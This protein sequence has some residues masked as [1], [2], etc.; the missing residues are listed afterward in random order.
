[1]MFL[2]KRKGVAWGLLG[3]VVIIFMMQ[4]SSLRRLVGVVVMAYYMV[5][6]IWIAIIVSIMY[7]LPR[8]H[9]P[10]KM[11]WKED[12]TLW[13]IIGATVLLGVKLLAG[14]LWGGFGK[15]PYDLSWYGIF[16]NSLYVVPALVGRELIRAYVIGSFARQKQ[17]QKMFW[18][19]TI[20]MALVQINTGAWVTVQG[21]ET[22]TV[23]LSKSVLPVICE[24]ILLS[25]LV[26]YGGAM[27]AILFGGIG[28]GF[29][30]LSPI[31]PTLEWFSQGVIGIAIPMIE[32]S[33]IQY[34]YGRLAKEV[35]PKERSQQG[36]AGWLIL[37]TFSVVLIWFVVGVFPVYPSIVLTG[38][39]EPKI[40]PGDVVLVEKLQTQEDLE[41]LQEGD[42]I[43]FSR[44]DIMITHRIVEVVADEYGNET[45][46]TK[47]DNNSGVDARLV[48]PQE[49][50]GTVNTVIPKIG[51]PSLWL[52][53]IPGH[54]QEEV[55][56]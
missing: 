35:K 29:W 25:Y 9:P 22:F 2:E 11:R 32:V 4:A 5:P 10:Q 8:V 43:Y 30:W 18:L 20:L 52:R 37:F 24:S 27:P 23:F 3:L 14:M 13:A 31:L 17:E 40:K 19:V 41:A 48:L 39:M 12:V 34:L 49:I 42:V 56:F 26:K 53:S 36:L 6:A 46:R 28:L 51:L 50:K 1:M 38:S 45:Y 55:V 15:S 44:G 47:G 21:M 7:V 54:V 33:I 16:M